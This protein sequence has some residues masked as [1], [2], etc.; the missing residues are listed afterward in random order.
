VKFY[1]LEENISSQRI[2]KAFGV[3]GFADISL[4]SCSLESL[5]A[6]NVGEVIRIPSI[7]KIDTLGKVIVWPSSI[8]V[9]DW[10]KFHLLLGKAK[11]SHYPLKI[12]VGE[13][14]IFVGT[15]DQLIREDNSVLVLERESYLIQIRRMADLR[16]VMSKY[17]DSRYF[18]DLFAEK[19]DI[20]KKSSSKKGK[21]FQEYRLLNSLPDTLQGF[22]V[23]ASTLEDNDGQASYK[24]QHVKAF[25]S[26][27]LFIN[28]SLSE[29]AFIHFLDELNDYLLMT[30]TYKRPSSE[31][32]FNFIVD[33]LQDRA[34]ELR[35]WGNYNS[36]NTFI[37]N[38][39]D[40]SCF[41]DVI[42]SLRTLFLECKDKIIEAGEV[43][44]HGDL[45][46]S[47]IL[48]AEDEDI[49][50]LIDP[51][52]GEFS[53]SYLS[54]YYDLAKFSHSLLGGYDFIINDLAQIDFDK[55]MRS[56]IVFPS[57]LSNVYTSNEFIQLV[58]KLNLCIR[59]V[60]I[61]EASLFLSMLPLH[62]ESS[63][64]VHMLALRGCEI[65]DEIR[66]DHYY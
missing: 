20:I 42:D 26:A 61:V 39:T 49:F 14:S 45:C 36:F 56:T 43:F 21:I 19:G 5:M 60:R 33:K 65:L 24:M 35:N 15:I 55:R 44:S 16:K 8:T 1:Y 40:Y 12:N 63:K 66:R 2:K 50:K 46:M 27:L 64:T 29:S 32:T 51:R 59:T 37:G 9:V 3:T 47:N 57:K 52:G 6:Q 54:P 34:I 7:E 18:N 41:E 58:S 48:Y 30:F 22:F 10:D 23:G 17:Y 13:S 25:D 62:I 28:G 11:A 31:Q 53:S 4:K 38:H